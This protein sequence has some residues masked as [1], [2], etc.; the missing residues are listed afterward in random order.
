MSRLVEISISAVLQRPDEVFMKLQ[1]L[2][3]TTLDISSIVAAHKGSEEVT[4]SICS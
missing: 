3:I 4:Y 2:K 1:G